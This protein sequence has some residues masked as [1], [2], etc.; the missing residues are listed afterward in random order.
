MA[1]CPVGFFIA[2][3]LMTSP[4]LLGAGPVVAQ[5]AKQACDLEAGEARTVTRVIDGDTLQV[6]GGSEVRL[7]GALA[8]RAFDAAAAFADWPLA[9][10]SRLELERL[11]LG[12]GVTL[13]FAGR[14]TDRYG[15][16]LAHAFVAGG[17]SASAPAWVQGAMLKLGMARAYAIEGGAHCLAE[18]IA[19]EAVARESAV[20]LWAET[21]YAVRGAD[22]VGALLRATGTFQVVEGT[23]VRVQELRG[24]TYIN[25]GEDQ[26]QDFTIVIR[27]RVRRVATAAG[28]TPEALTGRRVRVRGWIERRGGPMIEAHDPAVIELLGP[29]EEAAQQAV[30]PRRESR[31][32]ARRRVRAQP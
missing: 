22:D 4:A 31:A 12:R 16:L 13:A 30:V 32:E 17:E 11:V 10:R 7:V 25:F 21:A 14:R 15:R 23:A 1:R 6:D 8:P 3:L 27:D 19:H 20:G 24:T 2:A 5:R 28:I 29:A 9:E 18:L 26:R